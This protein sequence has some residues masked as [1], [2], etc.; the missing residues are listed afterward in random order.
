MDRKITIQQVTETRD[1]GGG[2]KQSWGYFCTMW[3]N[4]SEAQ[5]TEQVNADRRESIHSIL[6]TVRYRSDIT[7]K[8]RVVDDGGLVYNIEGIAEVTRRKLMKLTTKQ[9]I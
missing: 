9:T 1:S 6:W 3:A 7:T 2:V 8:M 5:G 4:K